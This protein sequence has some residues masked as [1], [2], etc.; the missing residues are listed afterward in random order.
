MLSSLTEP[1]SPPP[2]LTIPTSFGYGFPFATA[3]LRILKIFFQG[4]RGSSSS[5]GIV[6]AIHASTF[7]APA[8]STVFEYNWDLSA[9]SVAAAISAFQT[10]VVGPSLLQEFAAELVLGAGSSKGRVSFGLT[11]GWYAPADQFAAVIAPFLAALPQPASHKLTAGTYINSVQYLGGLG[12]LNTSGIPDS[13]DTFYAKSLMTPEGSPMSNASMTA[14]ANYLANQGF[15]TN[16]VRD[17]FLSVKLMI[18]YTPRYVGLVCGDRALWWNQLGDQ[19]C[20]FHC[21][22][23]R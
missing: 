17:P 19:Q 23:F 9:Q 22:C 5:F 18:V 14:F 12:R 4:L 3:F 6:T 21:Y 10:F 11:G 15:G 8:S 2:T 13:H 7:A 1:S 16:T 20:S